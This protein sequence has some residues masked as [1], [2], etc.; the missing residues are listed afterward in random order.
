MKNGVE[1]ILHT[2]SIDILGE[3]FSLHAVELVDNNPID[4]GFFSKLCDKLSEGLLIVNESGEIV[5]FNHTAA[6]Q[7]KLSERDLGR[8][9]TEHQGGKLLAQAI[10]ELKVSFS[11]VDGGNEVLISESWFEHCDQ[12]FKAIKLI[13]ETQSAETKQQL[14]MLSRV[15]SSTR[16]SCLITDTKGNLVYVNPGFEKLTKYTAAEALGKKPGKML[17]GKH[18]DKETVNRI[19]QKLKAREPFYEE[20]LNY[21]KDG[22]PYWIVLSVNPTFDENRQH[23][24]FVG[25][26]SDI[27][28]TKQQVLAQ[29]SQKEAMSQHSAVMEFDLQGKLISANPYCIQQFNNITETEFKKIVKGLFEHVSVEQSTRIK[30]G[31][32]AD[33]VIAVHY[34][35]R[36]IKFNCIISPV[37]D[38]NGAVNRYLVFGENISERNRVIEDTHE[39]MSQVLDR[40][41][42]IVTTINSV[43]NQT[44]LLA[45]NAAIEAA[46]AGEAGR[47]FAVVADE[48][49]TLAQSST[50]AATQIGELINE[51]QTHVDGL[52]TYLGN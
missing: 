15:V 44:N 5:H 29:L 32:S 51:T 7:L 17:Q 33:V 24:G 23:T 27:R 45:L 14:E 43:S 11:L 31:D 47:G 10:S 25:V 13:P 42:E 6:Q 20:I 35:N 49:R 34:D 36:E 2:T 38:L 18:T 50:D 46:R 40:I 21:T 4:A 28:E 41:Q 48:V 39:A 52:S 19:S 9:F 16:A 37:K 26:S 8:K 22:E 12:V 30:E 1:V 3:V